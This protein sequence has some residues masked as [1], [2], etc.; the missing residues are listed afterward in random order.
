M[1]VITAV[2]GPS[3]RFT[4]CAIRTT[5]GACAFRRRRQRTRRHRRPVPARPESPPPSRS[6]PGGTF[7]PAARHRRF[8]L[9]GAPSGD[10]PRRYRIIS[11]LAEWAPRTRSHGRRGLALN[12]PRGPAPQEA[13]LAFLVP[14]DVW[15]AEELRNVKQIRIPRRLRVRRDRPRVRSLRPTRETRCGP[16]QGACP[17]Q[18]SRW[19]KNGQAV[20]FSGLG[21]VCSGIARAGCGCREAMSFS[22]E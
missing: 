13:G 1:M 11:S 12:G 18:W 17:G 21:N 7:V 19:P 9:I 10:A 4:V 2:P 14:R 8:H 6:Q 15:L 20:T 16:G 3:V 22:S 5:G